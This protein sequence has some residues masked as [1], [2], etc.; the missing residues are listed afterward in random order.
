M[1]SYI[2]YAAQ[3]GYTQYVLIRAILSTSWVGSE[4]ITMEAFREL[5]PYYFAINVQLLFERHLLYLFI[6]PHLIQSL[7]VPSL[8]LSP[9]SVLSLL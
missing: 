2:S 8:C 3:N 5:S 7:R 9:N 1:A 4:K 6:L